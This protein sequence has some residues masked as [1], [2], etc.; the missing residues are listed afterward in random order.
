MFIGVEKTFLE[1]AKMLMNF[2]PIFVVDLKGSLNDVALSFLVRM[3]ATPVLG[4]VTDR[5]SRKQIYLTLLWLV[6]QNHL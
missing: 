2:L 6:I 3:V 1:R 5:R 4:W